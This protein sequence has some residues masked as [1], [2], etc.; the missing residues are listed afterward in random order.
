MPKRG[1]SEL[2]AIF[3]A[4]SRGELQNTKRVLVAQLRVILG[5]STSGNHPVLLR[6][7]T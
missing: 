5:M 7:R 2:D 1:G 3:E 6:A 4:A